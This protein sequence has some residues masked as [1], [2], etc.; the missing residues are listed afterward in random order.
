MRADVDMD[1]AAFAD[2]AHGAPYLGAADRIQSRIR[3]ARGVQRQVR[4]TS[5]GEILDRSH[6]IVGAGIYPLIRA[7][8]LGAVQPLLADVE[9]DHFGT[10]RLGVLRSC[11]PDRPLAEDR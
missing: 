9:R 3:V 6:R 7:E 11:K 4:V 1:V 8:R 5:T 10:H 2:K